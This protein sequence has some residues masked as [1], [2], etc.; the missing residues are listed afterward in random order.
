MTDQVNK[1][2]IAECPSEETLRLFVERQLGAEQ[3]VDVALHMAK[4]QIC[5]DKV[6]DWVEWSPENFAA[7]VRSLT[8]EE[9][10][11][12]REWVAH[13]CEADRI[14]RDV[15]QMFTPRQEHR[16]AAGGQT[17]DQLQEKFAVSSGF[18]HFQSVVD[19]S[20]RDYWHVE[21][22]I[23]V[24]VTEK[25]LI[26]MRVF[27]ND[28]DG[29]E[30]PLGKGR[31]VFCGVALDVKDGK[32]SMSLTEFQKSRKLSMISLS[33]DSNRDVPGAPVLGFGMRA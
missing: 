9:E 19:K 6:V 2:Q 17:A 32:A 8:E 5:K 25:S 24:N 30:Q 15:F 33:I 28:P 27:V 12:G 10:R 3:S 13:R 11:R 23:P 22:A 21:L 20:H 31:L 1:N 26:R 18:L 29:Q 14:W 16:A 4:C 7:N